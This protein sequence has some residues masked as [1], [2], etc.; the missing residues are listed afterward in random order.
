[1]EG[2]VGGGDKLLREGWKAAHANT[3]SS[4]FFFFPFLSSFPGLSDPFGH[5]LSIWMIPFSCSI[6]YPV[7]FSFFLPSLPPPLHKDR[8]NTGGFAGRRK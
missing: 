4:F 6:R 3:N 2:G 5:F 1:M 8:V 7:P